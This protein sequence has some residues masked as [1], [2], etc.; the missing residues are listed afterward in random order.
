M[1]WRLILL[2][3]FT[4]MAVSG[5]RQDPDTSSDWIEYRAEQYET[6]TDEVADP[7]P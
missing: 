6:S 7:S 1:V 3:L 4:V 2:G 5:Y